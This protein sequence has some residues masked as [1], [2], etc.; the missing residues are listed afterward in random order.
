MYSLPGLKSKFKDSLDNSVRPCPKIIKR[1][2]QD[3][4]VVKVLEAK[5]DFDPW[6]PHSEVS[7]KSTFAFYFYLCEHIRIICTLECRYRW[8]PEITRG[9]KMPNVGSRKRAAKVL[10]HWAISQPRCLEFWDR[11]WLTTQ[12][13]LASGKCLPILNKLQKPQE[14][15]ETNQVPKH[16]V[17][18]K[19]HSLYLDKY[20][21]HKKQ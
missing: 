8:R 14:R 9:S 2:H 12:E 20:Y 7:L 18:L 15:K 19:T 6:D 16:K 4:S 3:G 17:S 13:P 10:N 21:K 11:I 1:V 5:A